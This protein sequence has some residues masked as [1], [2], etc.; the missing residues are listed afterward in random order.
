MRTCDR[1][2]FSTEMERKKERVRGEGGSDI[3]DSWR[4]NCKVSW[5]VLVVNP[6]PSPVSSQ[7]S[8]SSSF[9]SFVICC[10]IWVHF[11]LQSRHITELCV[12]WCCKLSFCMGLVCIR[13]QA[14]RGNIIASRGSHCEDD[15]ITEANP[16]H[17]HTATYC[18]LF[19]TE[20]LL[21][22]DHVS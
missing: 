13:A 20:G 12:F 9:A 11:N 6:S 7:M 3:K 1:N 19:H 8:K 16:R 21:K 18:S 10:L 15:H 4:N 17:W 5:D 2:I 14:N 22:Q